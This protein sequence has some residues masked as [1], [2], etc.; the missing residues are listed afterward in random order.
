METVGDNNI[1]R[2]SD[3]NGTS[4]NDA[5]TQKKKH[6][7]KRSISI[8]QSIEEK[9]SDQMT[10]KKSTSQAKQATPGSS[11]KGVNKTETAIGGAASKTAK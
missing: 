10:R 5:L 1:S 7:R 11:K 2:R 4:S 8:D 9:K 6:A 3:N